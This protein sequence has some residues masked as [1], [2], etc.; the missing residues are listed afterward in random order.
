VGGITPTAPATPPPSKYE[1]D[2]A[3]RS[4]KLD[5]FIYIHRFIT[6]SIM[7]SFRRLQG[8]DGDAVGHPRIL[9]HN[10]YNRICLVEA[11]RV[12]GNSK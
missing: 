2:N 10:P 12:S 5:L 3:N 8:Q 7:F 4:F 1:V 11:E 9:F 6:R